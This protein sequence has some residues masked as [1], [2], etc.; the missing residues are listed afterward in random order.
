MRE[1]NNGVKKR[2]SAEIGLIISLAVF[3]F[4]MFFGIP[5]IYG[6]LGNDDNKVDV[7]GMGVGVMTEGSLARYTVYSYNIENENTGIGV[8]D[9]DTSLT[10]IC[11]H[12]YDRTF[13]A[14]NPYTSVFVVI[15][16]SSKDIPSNGTIK[17]RINRNITP[18]DPTTGVVLSDDDGAGVLQHRC[19]SVIRFLAVIDKTL[20]EGVGESDPTMLYNMVN[21]T[22]YERTTIG[23]IGST[24]V[25]KRSVGQETV[26][27]KSDFLMLECPFDTG[28][29]NVNAL[30]EME[31]L[32]VYL[33]MAY[34]HE[35]INDYT[36]QHSNIGGNAV[37]YEIIND[38][39]DIVVI[40]TE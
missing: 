11:F 4:V 23:Q 35:L 25:R 15:E 31:T 12:A 22:Y 3:L 19:T 36:I 33:Y 7:E 20:K 30:G 1:K 27:D 8:A 21:A 24:F 5:S 18:T 10:D 39:S 32:S 34:D 2:L 17:I 14:H 38:L 26:Y 40:Y 16:F 37:V 28:M 6:W 29:W 9:A 13:T